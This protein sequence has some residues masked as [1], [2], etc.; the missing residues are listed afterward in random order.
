MIKFKEVNVMERENYQLE[1]RV[2]LICS[3]T[4]VVATIVL[5]LLLH[6]QEM[7]QLTE[8][9]GWIIIHRLIPESTH[10]IKKQLLFEQQLQQPA[11]IASGKPIIIIIMII[12][13]I[14]LNKIYITLRRNSQGL[15]I[16][17]AINTLLDSNKQLL[18]QHHRTYLT[19]GM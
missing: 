15:H 7:Y 5:C 17:Q 12:I 2:H 3:S 19:Q 1:S 9:I 8:M 14:A 4:V 10:P 11:I 18:L 16:Q 6:T 13:I